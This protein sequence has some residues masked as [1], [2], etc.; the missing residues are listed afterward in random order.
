M[1][2]YKQLCAE[3]L[4]ELESAHDDVGLINEPRVNLIN[5]AR[6]ELATPA[7]Q[8]EPPSPKQGQTIKDT[9][10]GMYYVRDGDQWL[11]MQ[12]ATNPL[13]ISNAFAVVQSRLDQLADDQELM[14]YHW[15][16]G[17]WTIDHTNPERYVRLGES[18]GRYSSTGGTFGEAVNNLAALLPDH[19]AL[20]EPRIIRTDRDETGPY[21]LV[22]E[23]QPDPPTDEELL[24]TYGLA[25]RDHCYEGPI[26]DWPRRVERAATVAGLRAVLA[27]WGNS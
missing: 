20:V 21:I 27:R 2:D 25:K 11:V 24:R 10:T 4:Q 3:P 12:P 13:L 8:E 7:S 6:A 19:A 23:P 17:D 26:D 16:D 18:S 1:T 5:R 9:D 22:A 14:I 15:P